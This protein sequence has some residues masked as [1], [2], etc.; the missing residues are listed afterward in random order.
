MKKSRPLYSGKRSNHL[1]RKACESAAVMLSPMV[2]YTS[3][4]TAYEKPTPTGLSRNSRFAAAPP[5]TTPAGV[6]TVAMS[7]C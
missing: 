7:S 6:S 3:S 2:L 1:S 4:F 5:N